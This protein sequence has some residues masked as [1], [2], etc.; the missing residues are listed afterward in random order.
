MMVVSFDEFQSE[1]NL[2]GGKGATLARLFRE[3]YPVPRGL[4]VLP[5]AFLDEE[6]MPEAWMDA[7]AAKACFH[8]GQFR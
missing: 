4:I 2:A 7:T 8:Q 6:M 5:T 1:E 3:G